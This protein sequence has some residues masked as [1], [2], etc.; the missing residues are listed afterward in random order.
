MGNNMAK[1]HLPDGNWLCKY[2]C[3]KF[4]SRKN[5]IEHYAVCI[6]KS[7]LKK[8][9]LGRTITETKEKRVKAAID[10]CKKYFDTHN[11]YSFSGKHHSE[12]SRNKISLAR[13]EFIENN[14]FSTARLIKVNGMTVH[15]SLEKKFAEMLSESK[16]EWKRVT[17]L[18]K[19]THRYTPDFYIPSLNIF[20][21]IKGYFK[22][23]DL[24]KMFLA[25]DDNPSVHIKLIT[26]DMLLNMTL[27][28]IFSIEDFN[29]VY[30][31]EN[32]NFDNFKMLESLRN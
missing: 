5:L 4:K 14:S 9:S 10:S 21:E 30:D 2:C 26:N 3:A 19:K 16:I 11:H 17:L 1:Y 27:N 15:G 8:D 32:I 24:Y 31:R 12:E 25:L 20:I 7:S 22:D 28:E 18:Y 13:T 29:K 23:R 6:E